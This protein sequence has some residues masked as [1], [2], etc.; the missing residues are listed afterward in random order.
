[1]STDQSL[2]GKSINK[3]L[4]KLQEYCNEMKENARYI[5]F[6]STREISEMLA[7]LLTTKHF[8]CSCFT[9]SSAASEVGGISSCY[10][11]M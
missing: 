9:G 3:L 8:K 11:Q 7:D 2:E 6:V 5:V 10:I 1:M 4:K